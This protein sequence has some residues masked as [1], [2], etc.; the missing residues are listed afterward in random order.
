MNDMENETE[1]AK[2]HYNSVTG[3]S[4]VWHLEK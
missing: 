4:D 2:Q 1:E 3:E